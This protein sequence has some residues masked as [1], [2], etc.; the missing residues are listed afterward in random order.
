MLNRAARRPVTGRDKQEGLSLVEL[1]VGIAVGLFVVAGATVV[2]SNQLGDNR[3]L[4]LETQIQ[5]DLRAASDLIA[6]DLRRSGYWGKAESGIWNATAVAVA[7]NPYTPLQD[8][9]SGMPASGVRFAYSRDAAEN[10]AIDDATDRSGFKLEDSVIKMYVGSNWQALTDGTTLR[11][12]NF[13]VTLNSR[14]VDLACFNPCPIGAVACPPRQ[15]V[16]DITVVID[17]TAKNDA[18]VRRSARSNVRLRNDVIT[19]ACPA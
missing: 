19:G 7:T 11:V 12:T 2:V 16:R 17:G 3:R 6:R 13:Q 8:V 14:D 9:V 15:S 1:M 5:Q 10:N 18:S 4:M